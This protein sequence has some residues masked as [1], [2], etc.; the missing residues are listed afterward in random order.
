MSIFKLDIDA[1]EL[2]S[3]E[4]KI[5]DSVRDRILENGDYVKKEN[6]LIANVLNYSTTEVEDLPYELFRAREYVKIFPEDDPF[7]SVKTSSLSRFY[8]R[9]VRRLLR[10]QIVFNEF[11]LSASEEIWKK[12]KN[13]EDRISAIEKDKRNKGQSNDKG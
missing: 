12:M 5:A 7:S 10:Q 13:L 3:L 6:T 2:K 9:V 8:H 1:D 11:M 4:N